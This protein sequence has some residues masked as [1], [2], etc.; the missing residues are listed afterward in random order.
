MIVQPYDYALMAWF[1]A[2][3]L[4]LHGPHHSSRR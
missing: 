2:P 3:H 1:V 4:L